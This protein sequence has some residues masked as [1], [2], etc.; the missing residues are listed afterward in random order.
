MKTELHGLARPD[1]PT[2]R[3]AISQGFATIRQRIQNAQEKIKQLHQE[4]IDLEDTLELHEHQMRLQQSATK[5]M[6]QQQQFVLL[7]EKEIAGLKEKLATVRDE[8]EET[9][10]QLPAM[11]REL[12]K[13]TLEL[14]KKSTEV[15]LLRE[16]KEEMK[17]QL[18]MDGRRIDS[19]LMQ[20]SAARTSDASYR[21]EVEVNTVNRVV[22]I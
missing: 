8:L 10:P 9:K 15:Q 12:Q 14:V 20:I 18:V 21:V 3:T 5:E 7:Q 1:L 4:K 16:A 22:Y 6:E 2:S 11:Q 17:L 19:Y 13:I